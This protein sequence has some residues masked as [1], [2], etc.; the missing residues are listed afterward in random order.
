[1]YGEREEYCYR[2]AVDPVLGMKKYVKSML[3]SPLPN[4]LT[5]HTCTCMLVYS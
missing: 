3:T 1:M 2:T 5:L 4:T